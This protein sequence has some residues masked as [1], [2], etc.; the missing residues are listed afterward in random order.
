VKALRFSGLKRESQ[1]NG[2]EEDFMQG[3][4]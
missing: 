4:K 3:F 1:I 2:K